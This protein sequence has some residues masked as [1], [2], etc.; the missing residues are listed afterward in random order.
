[1]HI[2]VTGPGGDNYIFRIRRI[3]ASWFNDSCDM[4]LPWVALYMDDTD[5]NLQAH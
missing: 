3:G 1:M 4:A 5:L 2:C